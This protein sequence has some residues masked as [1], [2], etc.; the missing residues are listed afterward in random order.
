MHGIPTPGLPTQHSACLAP[1]AP[2]VYDPVN[3]A[4]HSSAPPVPAPLT[5]SFAGWMANPSSVAHQALSVG[6]IGLSASC[7]AGNK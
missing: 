4:M 2:R 6:P 5:A 3:M 1:S 7:N